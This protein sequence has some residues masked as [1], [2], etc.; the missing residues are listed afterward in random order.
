MQELSH[1]ARLHHHPE[2]GRRGS[3]EQLVIFP[4]P[5]RQGLAELLAP[6]HLSTGEFLPAGHTSVHIGKGLDF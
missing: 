2:S 4:S 5:T 6:G 1:R 3:A